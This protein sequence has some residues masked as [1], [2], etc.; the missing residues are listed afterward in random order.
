MERTMPQTD[1]PLNGE[2]LVSF[3]AAA[4]SAGLP[5]ARGGPHVNGSTL[6]RWATK[7]APAANGTRVRLEAVRI[8]GRW[9]TS[10]AAVHRFVE[11]LTVASTSDTTMSETDPAT[12]PARRARAARAA[13]AE[14]GALLGR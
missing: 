6:F 3:A 11:R 14:V 1:L 2:P 8:G 4:Q 13:T 12:T 9:A 5:G 7:G 10:V